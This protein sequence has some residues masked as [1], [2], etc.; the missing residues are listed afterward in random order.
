LRTRR[1]LSTNRDGRAPLL[2]LMQHVLPAESIDL[3]ATGA[4]RPRPAAV[5]G[6]P[7]RETHERE[8]AL[9]R[10]HSLAG[11]TEQLRAPELPGLRADLLYT[12]VAENV[13]DHASFL[14]DVN[15]MI[16]CWGEGARLMKWWT[17]QQGE[18]AHLRLLY[19]AGG[20]DDGTVEAHLMA[21]AQGGEYTD[22]G[23][24]MRSDGSS[25]LLSGDGVGNS[26]L[27]A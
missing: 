22:N 14:L 21:A 3:N 23:N 17:K 10:G 12:L 4:P 8:A 15:G 24:R 18:C 16:E 19:P 9:A 11:D 7:G 1:H 27:L 20:S 6:E 5:P 13:R 26:F 25:F 2:T